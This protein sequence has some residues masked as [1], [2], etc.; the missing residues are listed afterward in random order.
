VWNQ[1]NRI[2]KPTAERPRDSS[3]NIEKLS[4]IYRPRAWEEALSEYLKETLELRHSS[5]ING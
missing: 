1:E 4:Q 2:G 5:I 3:L